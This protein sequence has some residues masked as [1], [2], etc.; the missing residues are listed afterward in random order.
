V[1]VFTAEIPKPDPQDTTR[2]DPPGRHNPDPRFGDSDGTKLR[3]LVKSA[4]PTT[5][6]FSSK[7]IALPHIYALKWEVHTND[8]GGEK[9]IPY[10][11][12]T[13]E[14]YVN[15]VD[16]GLREVTCTKGGM[17]LSYAEKLIET[18][19]SRK[20]FEKVLNKKPVWL[21]GDL[22]EVL[23]LRVTCSTKRQG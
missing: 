4:L 1:V 16:D 17:E 22:A 6:P 8:G 3:R 21:T 18:P 12:N 11:I 23:T 15:K 7:L 20:H 13:F 14:Q 10:V 19:K 5:K 2:G 9:R